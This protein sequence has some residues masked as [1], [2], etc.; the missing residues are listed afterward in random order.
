[1]DTRSTLNNKIR[2]ARVRIVVRVDAYDAT[3]QD[4]NMYY[5]RDLGA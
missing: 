4:K 3:G 2:K 1:M 5:G